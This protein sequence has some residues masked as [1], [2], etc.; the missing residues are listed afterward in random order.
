MR[1]PDVP[2]VLIGVSILAI[3][4]W[5]IYNWMHRSMMPRK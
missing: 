3:L 5:A 2:E 1:S 4:V